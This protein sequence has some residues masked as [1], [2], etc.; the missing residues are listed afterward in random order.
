MESSLQT[1]L[2]AAFHPRSIAV[3]GAS[4]DLNKL[5]GS[6]IRLLR[7]AGYAGKIY[8]INP[9]EESI[10]GLKAY[11][12]VADVPDEVERAVIILPTRLVPDAVRDCA[13]KK[14]KVVQIYSAGFGEFGEAGKALEQELLAAAKEAGMRIIGPNCIGTYSPSGRI[15]FISGT[16]LQSGHVAFV[17]QSGGIA[18]DIIDRGEVLGIRFSK[19][20]SIGNSIDLDHPD[21]LEYL[22]EDPDTKVIG[23]YMESV[24]DGQRLLQLLKRLTPKKP[25]VVLKGGRTESGTQSVASHTGSLAGNYQIW[26]ALF[27]QTGVIPVTSVDEMLTALLALQSLKTYPAGRVAMIGNGGG[28]TVL[29]TDTL[30][31]RGLKLA[32]L[33][34]TTVERIAQLGVAN[35]G[36]NVNP[37]DLPAYELSVKEGQLFGD[38]VR[39]FSQDPNVNYILF[40]INLI[41]FATYGNLAEILEQ[42]ARQLET[43]D[44]SAVNLVGVLRSNEKPEIEAVRF[45][46]MRKLHQLGIPVFRTVEQGIYGIAVAANG[47]GGVR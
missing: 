8:P 1:A 27:R 13:K 5:G 4:N 41:P 3:I 24:R 44:P 6:E 11:P 23:C 26:Q 17:S 37:I 31:E 47:L 15:S 16:S 39:A 35:N 34:S 42:F 30:E 33:S 36:R 9:K 2:R 29:A 32:K 14:V 40:H 43:V 46:A 45:E 25:V 19:V 7:E 10:Q 21:Y 28:A 12:S 18:F 38:L 20:I 22:L